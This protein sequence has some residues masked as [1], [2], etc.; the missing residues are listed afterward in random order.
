VHRLAFSRSAIIPQILPDVRVTAFFR[1][2]FPPESPVSLFQRSVRNELTSHASVVFSTLVVVWLSVLLVRLLGEAAAGRIGAD[3]VVGMATFSTINA[4][5]T[6]VSVTVFIAVL[7]TV[8]RNYRESEMVVWFA[9]GI[10]LLGWIK[11]VLHFA[12][13]CAVMVAALTLGVSPW[14]YRQISEY[15]ER[16]EN[17]SDI[18]KV[19]PG[20]F[21]ESGGTDRVF[22]VESANDAAD[23]VANVFVRAIEAGR[24]SIIT[25]SGGRIEEAANGDRF[26]VLETGNRYELTPGQPTFRI[27]D[28]E[29]YGVRLE[30]AHDFLLSDPSTKLRST[31]DLIQNPGGRALGELLWRLGLPILAINLA[32]LAIPLGAVNPR[33]GRSGD[34]VIALL[35]A[36][37]YLNLVSLSQASVNSGRLSFSVGV[38]AIHA[39]VAAL[40]ATLLYFRLRLP[41]PKRQ[42]RSKEAKAG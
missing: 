14:A 2:S 9:S 4:L 12:I 31:P 22:F 27:M 33:L 19:T 38:W 1:P 5:P 11:P 30:R 23:R 16:Y 6:I 15:R 42:R 25:A 39:I 29:R 32:L 8:T 3:A 21:G 7:T 10:S 18:A 28:F 35:V 24:V 26:M 34:V 13:P 20:Q 36:L 17:R 41:A 37:L 40:T